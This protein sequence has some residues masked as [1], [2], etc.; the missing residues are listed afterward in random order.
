MAV[1]MK[2]ICIKAT[3]AQKH[4]E[5]RSQSARVKTPSS[6]V[7]SNCYSPP[8]KLSFSLFKGISNYGEKVTVKTSKCKTLGWHQHTPQWP[9][10]SFGDGELPPALPDAGSSTPSHH[11]WDLSTLTWA[12][13]K[14]L[15]ETSVGQILG[16]MSPVSREEIDTTTMKDKACSN[17]LHSRSP[18]SQTPHLKGAF[19]KQETKPFQNRFE[20]LNKYWHY[21]WGVRRLKIYLC[22]RGLNKV[23]QPCKHKVLSLTAEPT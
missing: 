6:S 2:Y 18:K 1:K 3:S 9:S 19:K 4:P 8:L 21:P 20:L 13:D 15:P 10:L 22:P 16:I 14:H 11:S 23:L 12:V 5:P 17:W 7:T